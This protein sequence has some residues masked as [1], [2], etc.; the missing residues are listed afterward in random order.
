MKIK[1][2]KDKENIVKTLSHKPPIFGKLAA[3]TIL[4]AITE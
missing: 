4:A 1:L 3:Y 2:F